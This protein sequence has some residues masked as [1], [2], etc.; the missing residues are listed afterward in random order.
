MS[1]LTLIALLAAALAGR[2]AAD[3]AATPRFFI[4]QIDIRNVVRVPAAIVKS[5]SL[6]RE[7]SEYTE[8]EL[9]A[10]AARLTRLPFLTAVDFALE[11]G[12][13]RGRHV[14]VINVTEAKPFFFL[15]DAPLTVHTERQESVDFD[16][17]PDINPDSVALGFRWFLG[18]HGVVHLGLTARHDRQEFTSDY[19]AAAIGYTRY[20]LFG[21]HAFATVN[22]R[23]PLDSPER[24]SISPQL[25]AGIPL[26]TRQTLT[27]DYE[28]TIFRRTASRIFGVA[29]GRTDA[30]RLISFTW[31]YNS[32]D[33]PFVPRRGSILRIAPLYSMRDRAAIGF[34]DL[35]PTPYAQHVNGFGVDVDALRYWEVSPRNSVS[36][37]ALAGWAN[38]DDRV[39]PATLRVHEVRWKPSYEVAQVGLSHDLR[40]D[41]SQSG[42][43]RL[44]L[45]ARVIRRQR[46]V[47]RG[48]EGFGRTPN[49]QMAYQASARW[50]RRSSWGVLRLG[51]GYSWR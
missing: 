21:T 43:S 47:T 3:D 49:D 17:D 8:D 16:I 31:T 1:R 2:A 5:E 33:Q 29:Y 28:D 12:S 25:V 32:T 13:E 34:I 20:D 15:I 30:Q 7:G 41:E 40:R 46:E 24:G 35:N 4:E 18:G 36:A 39:E 23:V 37:G 11:K 6:L 19:S 38:V 27:L 45:E 10:A 22:L 9:R 44:E 51:F 14:L 50:V 26:T 48:D 42:D